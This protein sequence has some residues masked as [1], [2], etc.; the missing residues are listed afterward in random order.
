MERKI[1]DGQ[2]EYDELII[3]VGYSLAD[4][5]FSVLASHGCPNFRQ[6]RTRAEEAG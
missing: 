2:D 1:I 6:W 3:A 5:P 4:T